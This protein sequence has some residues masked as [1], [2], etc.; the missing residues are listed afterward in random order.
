MC[1]KNQLNQVLRA[2]SGS[3]FDFRKPLKN[4]YLME[5]VKVLDE[6]FSSN[7]R[8][9]SGCHLPNTTRPAGSPQPLRLI[10]KFL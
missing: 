9:F 1:K 6:H 3:D 7:I 2:Q 5:A 4:K 10:D 8:V